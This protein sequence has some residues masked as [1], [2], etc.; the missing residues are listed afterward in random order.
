MI[1]ISQIIKFA[2][3]GGVGTFCHYVLL[4]IMV[5]HNFNP[6]AAS[7]CGM[8]AGAVV[9]YLINYYITFSSSKKH[10]DTL[11]R[12][13]PMA[14]TGFCLNTV[15]LGCALECFSMPLPLSQVMATSGQFLFGFYISRLCVF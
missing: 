14:S 9:V 15:I 4:W 7:G 3:S 5:T 10:Y 2:V 11:K 1:L 12:F 13:L 6:V 8:I